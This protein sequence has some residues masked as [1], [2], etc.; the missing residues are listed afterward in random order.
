MNTPTSS[1]TPLARGQLSRTLFGRGVGGAG[2]AGGNYTM[3]ADDDGDCSTSGEDDDDEEGNQD[4]ND[5]AVD[6]TKSEEASEEATDSN[7]QR[8]NGFYHPLYPQGATV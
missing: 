4:G 6:E 5:E 2:G 3:S 7:V 8:L 1:R